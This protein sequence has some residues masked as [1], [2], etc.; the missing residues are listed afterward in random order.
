MLVLPCILV[1]LVMSLGMLGRHLLLV[2][3]C[4]LIIAV[5]SVSFVLTTFVVYKSR[6]KNEERKIKEQLKC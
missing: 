3:P 6:Q 1:L 4:Q 2:L 5:L